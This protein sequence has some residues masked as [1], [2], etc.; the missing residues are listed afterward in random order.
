MGVAVTTNTYMDLCR[1]ID[2]LDIRISSLERERE[3]LRR[4]MFAN[5]PSGASTVDYSKER[6]S[7]S[8]EPFPLNEI[9]SRINGIDKSLE[10]LYK[11]MNEKELAKRQMEEKISEFEGLDYKVAYLRMQGKSLIEI[12]DE[13]G[14]SYDWIKK[15]SS[16][17]N[18]G[19]FKALL[20]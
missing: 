2:I 3:H 13:L 20:D 12:A 18:K 14:Y 7:S 19:T 6:V 11:V 15:V 16:R 10:P 8:Y 5:A 17:I 4:M 1:E 9:V